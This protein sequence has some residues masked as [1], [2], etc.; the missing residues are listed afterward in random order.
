MSNLEKAGKPVQKV[1]EKIARAA[2]VALAGLTAAP[3]PTPTEA[4]VPKERPVAAELSAVQ[5]TPE[6]WKAHLKRM[7]E[8]GFVR[9]KATHPDDK[10]FFTQLERD[11]AQ[12][13]AD[14]E[15]T[16]EE[17]D[18]IIGVLTQE[19]KQFT[20][21]HSDHRRFIERLPK[22]TFKTYTDSRAPLSPEERKREQEIKVRASELIPELYKAVNRIL[23]K[24]DFDSLARDLKT[25]GANAIPELRHVNGL[26]QELYD[27][28]AEGMGK[29]TGVNGAF[30]CDQAIFEH[31]QKEKEILEELKKNPPP[32]LP[33]SSE[34]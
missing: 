3:I 21:L 1:S 6:F 13:N 11:F 25:E 16:N 8:I 15:R 33:Y 26:F 32:P 20:R 12:A 17:R 10:K 2:A 29:A 31:I 14:T 4:A 23:D 28:C 18:K 30:A 9:E 34:G 7:K 5:W 24:R 22:D 19:F 27:L